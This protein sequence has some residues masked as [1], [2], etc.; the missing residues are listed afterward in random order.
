MWYDD[1][2][3][4]TH[5]ISGIVKCVTLFCIVSV[6]V[7]VRWCNFFFYSDVICNGKLDLMLLLPNSACDQV[8]E[9]DERDKMVMVVVMANDEH[10]PLL[11]SVFSIVSLVS[12]IP[13]HGKEQ[14]Q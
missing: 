7:K 13:L 1:C 2:I 4:N 6:I 10:G 11:M 8:E 3:A 9:N 5:H 12:P 14:E